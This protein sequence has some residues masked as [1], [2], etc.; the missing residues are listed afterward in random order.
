MCHSVAVKPSFP[1]TLTLSPGEREQLTAVASC[2]RTGLASSIGCWEF[3]VRCSMFPRFMVRFM[4][5]PRDGRGEAYE[6][7]TLPTVA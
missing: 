2:A 3:D 7:A 6:R 5:E 4:G 1:L